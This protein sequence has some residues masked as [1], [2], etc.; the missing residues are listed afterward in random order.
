MSLKNKVLFVFNKHSYIKGLRLIKNE[1]AWEFCKRLWAKIL[2]RDLSYEIWYKHH[3]L[4]E[5][6]LEKQKNNKFNY[7]PKISIIVPCYKTPK[8]FL[9][10]M[11]DSVVG[12]T[13]SN[14]ELCIADGSGT[15]SP[16]KAQLEQ[17]AKK[18]NRIKVNYLEENYGISKNS[19]A[20]LKLATGEY[21]ALLD[22]DDVIPKNALYE[23]VNALQNTKHDLLY[24]D[25]DFVSE[26]L[27]KHFAP[28]FKPDY[29]PELLCTHNYITHLLVVKKSLL[30]E[31]GAFNKKYDGAQDF[32]L[33]FRCCEKAKSIYHIPKI[34]YHWRVCKN[35]VASDSN[36]KL[37]AYEAG[38]KAI[39]DHL[40]RQNISATVEMLE[41]PLGYY[42][43]MYDVSDNPCVSI[44]IPNKDHIDDLKTCI[45]SLYS[46]NNYPHFEIIV[47]ENNSEEEKTFEYYKTL[48][49]QH[50]NVKIVNYKGEFN[51]SKINNFGFSFVKSDYVLFLN[52]DTK[53]IN[54][55]SIREMLGICKKPEV[56]AV[57]AKLLFG[58]DTVQH[59]GVVIGFGGCAGHVFSGFERNEEGY[60][61]RTHLNCNYSAVTAACMMTKSKTFK[62]TGMFNE[63]F[64]VAFNDIDYCLKVR[65]QNQYVVYCPHSLWYHFE[66]K[67]RGYETTPLKQRRFD[68]EKLLLRRKWAKYFEDGDPFYNINFPIKFYP[69]Q[70]RIEDDVIY[71]EIENITATK[72]NNETVINIE[73][74]CISKNID[75]CSIKIMRGNNEIPYK[76]ESYSRKDLIYSN[77]SKEEVQNAGFKISFTPKT[78]SEVTL[79][80]SNGSETAKIPIDVKE[81][82]YQC[83]GQIDNEKYKDWRKTYNIPIDKNLAKNNNKKFLLAINVNNNDLITVKASIMSIVKQGYKNFKIILFA[84]H[85]LNTK[86]NKYLNKLENKVDNLTLYRYSLNKPNNKINFNE[87]GNFDYFTFMCITDILEK[88]CLDFVDQYISTN[89]SADFIYT[90][91]DCCDLKKNTYTYPHFKPDLNIDMLRSWNYVGSFFMVSYN[92]LKKIDEFND[93][94][95]KNKIYDF[96]LKSFENTNNILHIPEVLCHH[97]DDRYQKI[98]AG[99]YPDNSKTALNTLKNHYKRCNLNVNLNVQKNNFIKTTYKIPESYKCSIIIPNRDNLSYLKNCINSINKCENTNYEIVVVENNSEKKETFEYYKKLEKQENIKIV[100]QKSKLFNYSASINLG[101]KNSSGDYLLLLNN[102]TKFINKNTIENMVGLCSRKDVGIVGAK[103]LYE[104]KTVQHSGVTLGMGGIAAHNFVGLDENDPGYFSRNITTHDLSAVT[105]ACMMVKRNIF[106]KIEGFNENLAVTFNDIDFCLRVREMG[107]LIIYDPNIKLFHFESKS[108]GQEDTDDKIDRFQSEIMLFYKTWNKVLNSGDPY[109]NKNLSLEKSFKLN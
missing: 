97:T 54:P 69:Y 32:D 77:F 53:M 71:H 83:N 93:L 56:G 100:Y 19:N 67:S 42:H 46:V 47:I 13:Y 17:Y 85:N 21:I 95:L 45:D 9:D 34:L 4:N 87:L 64:E 37:Y 61:L 15:K 63:E 70:L 24:T 106:N 76:K 79:T 57:G 107:Y 74:Y 11:I 78:D 89:N 99:V 50:S 60:K 31:V 29:S 48:Q 20:A 80:I 104:D 109:Y 23:V 98:N 90:D 35:S 108:R 7:R 25:E 44:L 14:W 3:L 75:S 33:T 41:N 91:D 103:L 36:N 5:K 6:D 38:K 73:G 28:S 62:D 66:S 49:D 27:T 1:G 88:N 40:Q 84:N 22:H 58:D 81:A 102:D 92:L 59:A 30:D 82:I 52:N 39:E 96:V 65:D 94:V 51:Y 55:N 8:K 68:Y 12:Q 101:A 2:S 26:D 72:E 43:V 105:A 86:V 10:Q 18:Y 16:I